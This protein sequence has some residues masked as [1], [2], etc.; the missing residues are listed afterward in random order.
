MVGNKSDRPIDPYHANDAILTEGSNTS[1]EWVGEGLI[2]CEGKD[3][4]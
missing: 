1:S 2:E 3:D 4:L